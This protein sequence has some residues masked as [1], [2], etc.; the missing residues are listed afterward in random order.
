MIKYDCGRKSA[1]NWFKNW[2]KCIELI[3]KFGLFLWPK[4]NLNDEASHN[5][6]IFVCY[7]FFMVLAWIF[8]SF[9]RLKKFYFLFHFIYWFI[10]R[11]KEFMS[12]SRTDLFLI[13]P[14]VFHKTILFLTHLKILILLKI[15]PF[16][17]SMTM[18]T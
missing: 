10:S 11:I 2:E 3:N 1:L 17:R 13:W 16:F 5:S 15:L 6:I 9:G 7:F 18:R 14:S 8:K 12:L 4:I